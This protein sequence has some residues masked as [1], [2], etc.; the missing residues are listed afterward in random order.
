MKNYLN[1]KKLS[2]KINIIIF[3]FLFFIFS[4]LGGVFYFMERQRTIEQANEQMVRH[5]D[6]LTLVLDGYNSK[7]KAIEIAADILEQKGLEDSP[8][9]EEFITEV[10]NEMENKGLLKNLKQIIGKTEY[11]FG[12]YPVLLTK[13]GKI[14]FHPSLPVGKDLSF[15]SNVKKMLK[16]PDYTQIYYSW[17]P[18]SENGVNKYQFHKY[19]KPMDVYIVVTF[20]EKLMFDYLDALEVKFFLAFVISLLILMI[21]MRYALKNST[22][23]LNILVEKIKILST[24]KLIDKL[25]VEQNDEVGKISNSLNILIDGLRDSSNFAKELGKGNLETKYNPMSKNDVLGNALI[26]MKENLQKAKKDESLRQIEDEKR[27]WTT[28]GIAKFGDILRQNNDNIE[29]LVNNIIQNL[30]K[31]LNANQGGLFIYNDNDKE[32]IYLDLVASYAYDRR[33]YIS[34]KVQLNE[35]LVGTCA[36]EKE[37]I[38]LLEIPQDYIEITSGLGKSNPTSL[39]IVPLKLEDQIFGIIELASFEKMEKHEIEFVERIAEN[40][41]SS[42]FSVKI[43]TQTSQLL[44]QSKQ[45]SEEMAAQEEEMRQ[46]IEELQAVHENMATKD[47][48]MSGII[49]ALN[50]TTLVFEYDLDGTIIKVN[51]AVGKIFNLPKEYFIGKTHHELVLN[52]ENEQNIWNELK[53]GNIQHLRTY[54]NINNKDVWLSENYTPIFNQEGSILKILNIAIDISENRQQA[55]ELKIK[56]DE[57]KEKEKESQDNIQKLEI[58][59]KEMNKVHDELLKQEKE[60]RRNMQK[61]KLLNEELAKKDA[62]MSGVITALNDTTFVAEFDLFGKYL[63]INES[64]ANLLGIESEEIVGKS[65]KYVTS[66]EEYLKF[67]RDLKSG[68]QRFQEVEIDINKDKKVWLSESYT[69]IYD[70]DG[71]IIKVLNI[72]IDITKAKQQAIELDKNIKELK[73]KEENINQINIDLKKREEVLNKTL[74]QMKET[75]NLMKQEEAERTA[76]FDALSVAMY[77]SELDGEGNYISMNQSL[78]DFLEKEQTE[79]IGTT[80]L[81]KKNEQ[82]FNKVVSGEIISTEINY[83]KNEKNNWMLMNYVPVKNTENEVYKILCV[84]TD[85]TENKE[86][87]NTL[88]EQISK[89]KSQEQIILKQIEKQKN[90]QKQMINANKELIEKEEKLKQNLLEMKSVQDQM[91]EKENEMKGVVNAMN[92]STYVAEIDLDGNYL[93]INNSFAQIYNLQKEQ[94]IGRKHSQLNPIDKNHESFW[95]K[96]RFGK[97]Q[98]KETLLNI[99]GNE[100]WLLETFTPILDNKKQPAKILNIAID[101]TENKKQAKNL[102]RQVEQ[103]KAQEEIIIKQIQ[104]QKKANSKVKDAHDEIQEKE[105]TLRQNLKQ[106]QLVRLE[107]EI[108][109]KELIKI[110]GAIKSSA[111]VIELDFEGEILEL[112][113][114][115]SKILKTDNEKVISEKINDFVDEKN[116]F[117]TIKEK[118]L[119]GET[120]RNKTKYIINGENVYFDET[121]TPIF[122]ADSKPQRILNIAIDLTQSFEQSKQLEQ[123]EDELKD[124]ENIIMDNVLQLRQIKENLEEKQNTLNELTAKLNKTKN[125]IK[126][127]KK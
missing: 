60:V 36:L 86:K 121:Y 116:F 8:V 109:K 26:E 10:K 55:S 74:L 122:D 95:N 72:S 115:A 54:F 81:I 50:N 30:V 96:L 7:N 102:K 17:P 89:L 5:L 90:L 18:N 33:K 51:E 23:L 40:I 101:I 105:K 48:E 37:T 110:V 107:N 9:K 22:S 66:E 35:G 70:K 65:S 24:G 32:D 15:T 19:Y 76:I 42:L 99:D 124:Q 85:I 87:S 39:L 34:K 6:D 1:N 114:A 28:H 43:H 98:K 88:E 83:N 59:H 29:I 103:F 77:V 100:I 62:E 68:K 79:I 47:A 63:K 91:A 21:G 61:M 78:C 31:Y 56:V 38:Y 119:R 120:V 127:L 97:I 2:S 73:E 27:N 12:G 57:L 69:P 41:A 93:N 117:E 44:E 123:K 108:K 71:K 126:R 25:K 67:W 49:N 46:N 118:L 45:Q 53:E 52:N 94:I 11:L 80:S 113:N 104:I 82:D 75:Q 64:L 125:K 111:I 20:T 13:E 92:F 14:F 58:T 16:S 3:L 4:I 106:L 84:G 112:N